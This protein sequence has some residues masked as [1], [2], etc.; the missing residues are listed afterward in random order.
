MLYNFEVSRTMGGGT[1]LIYYIK[2]DTR[3]RRLNEYRWVA[4]TYKV[5]IF[6]TLDGPEYSYKRMIK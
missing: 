3:P 1:T 5:E 2:L 6:Q 4:Y